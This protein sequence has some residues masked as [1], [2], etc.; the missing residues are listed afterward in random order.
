MNP[1]MTDEIMAFA[2]SWREL[3]RRFTEGIS[4]ETDVETRIVL[5]HWHGML[6]EIERTYRA[7]GVV[8]RQLQT[9]VSAKLAATGLD[10]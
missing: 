1:E 8:M 9:A 7:E 5:E 10:G 6:T 3:R 4:E 2:K